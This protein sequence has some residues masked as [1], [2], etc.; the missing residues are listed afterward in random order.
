V[1]HGKIIP[2]FDSQID[3]LVKETRHDINGWDQANSSIKI[4]FHGEGK[5]EY[6]L[7]DGTRIICEKIKGTEGNCRV[8]NDTA[9]RSY[10]FEFR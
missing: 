1:L 3:T 10:Q 2:V 8:I 5:D 7:W 4:I 9:G 6:T